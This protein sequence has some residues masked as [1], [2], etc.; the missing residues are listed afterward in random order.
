MRKAQKKQAEEFTA[1]LYQAQEEIERTIKDNNAA[2]AMD[3]LVQC[4]EGAIKLGELIEV[5]EGEGFPTVSLLEQ[6]CELAYQIYREI[7]GNQDGIDLEIQEKQIE[8]E[9]ID[10]SNI[11]T[12]KIWQKLNRLL[13]EIE[14]SVKHTI[15]VRYEVVFLPYKASMW[16]SLESVWMAANA[17]PDCDAYVIP[18][19]YYDRN[20][21]GSFGKYHYEGKEMPAEI[22]ITYYE[23]YSLEIRKPD[24]IFIHNPYDNE[25]TVTS[26]D[27]RFYSAELKKCTGCLVYIPYYATTGGMSEGQKQCMAYDVVDYIMIQAEK[28]R[29]FFDS[30]LPEE[31]LVPLGSPKFDR[32]IRICKEPPRPPKEWREKIKGKKVYFYNTSIGG[33]LSNTTAF[34]KKME[35]VFQCFKDRKETCLLWRPHPLLESTFSSMRPYQKPIYDELKQY[36]LSNQIGIYDTTPNISTSIALSDAYIGDAGSSVPSLFGIAGKPLFILDN[37]IAEKP[38]KDDWRG[39]TIL[40]FFQ[41]GNDKWMITYGDKLYYSS[42]NNY[43]YQYCCDL[44][45]YSG[46]YYYFEVISI[47]GKNYVCPTN[48]QDILVV[49]QKGVEKR[50][51]LYPYIEQKRAFCGAISEKEYLFLIPDNYPAVVRYNTKNG[52]IRYFDENVSVFQDVVNGEKRIGG[53]CIHKDYLFISS[54]SENYVLAIHIVSGEQQILGIQTSSKGGEMRLISDGAEIWCLPFTGNVVLRWDPYT[55]KVWEYSNMPAGL[56]GENTFL[57]YPAMEKLFSYAVFY[58]DYVY[59]SPCWANMFVRIDKKTG[60]IEKWKPSFQM[61][62]EKKNSYYVSWEKGCFIHTSESFGGKGALFFSNL[63]RKLYDIN[64]ETGDSQEIEIKF[65]LEELKQ[66]EPGF[67]EISDWL[68]YACEENAFNTLSDFLDGSITGSAFDKERQQRAYEKTAA[69]SDGTSGEK[70]YQ[71]VREKL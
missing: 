63:D 42:E 50:I 39:K 56:E 1:L 53:Y 6:Y 15:K 59:L 57:G 35:Y 71:F 64:L 49:S 5:T 44:S 62:R 30:N 67:C 31:K 46:G 3:L 51:P 33:M 7:A 2:M 9:G 25:N 20:A 13:K 11:N 37:N 23:D 65:S 24:A 4:Q 8:L 43:Q 66:H 26:V 55:G 36:F 34:L 47:Q 54:P 69:N 21:D 14:D 29:K 60:K 28:F 27:P 41:N 61:R 58:N 16:D 17:D 10:K 70:I 45:N 40:G 19:P 68:S 52:E 48:A 18:V 38:A 22:P 32:T 12:E